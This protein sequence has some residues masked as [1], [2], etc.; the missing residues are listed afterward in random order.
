M[1]IAIREDMVPA[2][3]LPEQLALLASLGIEGIELCGASL[4]MSRDDLVALFRDAPV[5][6]SAIEGI[7]QLTSPDPAV[8][9]RARTVTR[10]RLALAGAL[11]VPAGVLV[12]P[13]FGELPPHGAEREAAILVEELVAL[14]PVAREAGVGIFLE[15][16]NRYEATLVN[17]IAQ[18]VEIATAAAPEV[19]VMADFFHMNIEEADLPESIRAAGSRLTYVHL[20]DSNRLQPGYGHLDFRPGFAALREIGYDGWLGIECRIAGPWEAG[21][22]GTVEL[23]RREW[24]AAM[25]G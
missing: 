7:P 22:R 11:G 8:R 17:R 9:E 1:R 4:R 23:V 21:V 12:V 25:E 5:K 20:A 18:G 13:Q 2:G 16:L 3:P 14:A 19:G 15:P 6:P 10:E 24:S